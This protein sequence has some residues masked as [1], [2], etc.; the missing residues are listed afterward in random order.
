MTSLDRAGNVLRDVDRAIWDEYVQLERDGIRREAMPVLARLVSR[1]ES[2][3]PEVRSSFAETLTEAVLEP[4]A[5]SFPIRHPLFDRIVLPVLI[6]NYDRNE[7]GS[8]RVLL[9]F[10]HQIHGGGLCKESIGDEI[11]SNVVDQ[12]V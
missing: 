9:H 4:P 5:Q 1:L 11:L 10:F 7:V 2:Y 12:K 3:P 8:A 6:D